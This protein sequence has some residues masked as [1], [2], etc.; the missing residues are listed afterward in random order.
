MHLVVAVCLGYLAGPTGGNWEWLVVLWLIDL[1]ASLIVFA[2]LA[3][4]IP[5]AWR[6]W[7]TALV[8]QW[9]IGSV[10]WFW[11]ARFVQSLFQ[12]PPVRLFERGRDDLR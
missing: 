1:P 8:I 9:L 7:P 11:L 4:P 12:G 5:L 2:I 10:W 3:L 6:A